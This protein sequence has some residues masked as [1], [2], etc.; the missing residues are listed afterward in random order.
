MTLHDPY[1]PTMKAKYSL[2]V[3]FLS[4]TKNGI[5]ILVLSILP[6]IEPIMTGRG[7]CV[8]HFAVENV[9]GCECPTILGLSTKFSVIVQF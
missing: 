9:V 1:P 3:V 8:E 5:V 6:P 2:S 4:D 7:G